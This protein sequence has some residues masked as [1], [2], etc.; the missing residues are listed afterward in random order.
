MKIFKIESLSTQKYLSLK[1]TPVVHRDNND[2]RAVWK[3]YFVNRPAGENLLSYFNQ[4]L[5]VG[6]QFYSRLTSNG[7]EQELSESESVKRMSS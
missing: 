1:N 7:E 5:V 2:V 3:S 4:N 6:V